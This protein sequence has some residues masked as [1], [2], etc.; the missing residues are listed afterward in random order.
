MAAFFSSNVELGD[1]ARFS[2]VRNAARCARLRTDAARDFR[3][4]FLAEAILG[5]T[6]SL[7]WG[8][9]LT[10]ETKNLRAARGES[11]ACQRF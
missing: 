11:K 10:D 8:K 1:C 7:D 9:T 4:F 6:P 5:T 2:A 3:M